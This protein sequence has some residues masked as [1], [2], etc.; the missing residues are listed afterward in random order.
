LGLG[1]FFRR[2][3]NRNKW[4]ETG[5]HIG[6]KENEPVEAAQALARRRRF[7]RPRSRLC[8]W[9]RTASA[10]DRSLTIAAIGQV[11]RMYE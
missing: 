9:W 2:Q 1:P 8:V 4:T 11:N 7:R 3:I 10:T 5:L 6:Q